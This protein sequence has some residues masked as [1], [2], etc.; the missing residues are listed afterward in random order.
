LGGVAGAGISPLVNTQFTYLDVGVNVELQPHVH[1]N[2]DVSLHVTLDISSVTGQVNLGGINEPIIG[3]R[4]VEE[5]V[6]LKEGQVSLLGGLLNVQDN[7]TKTGIPGLAN[8]PFL[9]HLFRGDSI[10]RER[11][12][13][14]IALIPHVVRRP[15]ITPENVRG[16]ASGPTNQVQVRRSPTAPPPDL[17]IP[18][19]DN[20]P[21]PGGDAALAKA[22]AQPP[23]GP[24]VTVPPAAPVGGALPSGS[25]GPVAAPVAPP[26]VAPPAEPGALMPPAT[27][28]PETPSGAPTLSAA[29]TTPAKPAGPTK[30]RFG[31]EEIAKHPGE[32][33]TVTVPVDD[34]RDVTSAQFI[35]NYDP[36][37]LSLDDVTAGKFWSG[38]GEIPLL[39]KNV[40]NE[41]GQ[42]N[43]RLSRKPG[44]VSVGGSGT[45]LTLSFKAVAAGTTAVSAS[46]ITLNNS[47][48]QMMASGSPKVPVVIK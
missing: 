28:P 19:G 21:E 45:L 14:M 25:V 20:L 39:I 40:Q 46:N 12:E 7:T 48:A 22:I 9:G 5:F 37:I 33:F 17:Q 32:T 38:D 8:I 1:E 2:G 35:I 18:P 34:A 15:D 4:K 31:E 44:S 13:L 29:P 23:A 3:Q 6:R 26:P 30:I 36:K 42:A 47:N 24:G 43:V 11:D 10:D 16:V 27:A 41:A